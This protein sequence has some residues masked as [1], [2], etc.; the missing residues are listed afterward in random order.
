MLFYP[1]SAVLSVNS[2]LPFL[3][4]LLLFVLLLSLGFTVIISASSSLFY[5]IDSNYLRIS[6]ERYREVPREKKL[7]PLLLLLLLAAILLS[8]MEDIYEEFIDPFD[9]TF[10]K[11]WETNAWFYE[12]NSYFCSYYYISPLLSYSDPCS[13]SV[14]PCSWLLSNGD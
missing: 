1:L 13:Y 10:N 5:C 12:K 2:L 9:C 7:F 8:L 4:M 11:F 3:F 14:Y 6:K